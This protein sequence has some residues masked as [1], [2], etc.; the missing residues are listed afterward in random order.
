MVPITGRASSFLVFFVCML[1][2]GVFKNKIE[3][4]RRWRKRNNNRPIK[5][6]K[7]IKFSQTTSIPPNPNHYYTQISTLYLYTYMASFSS[8][9]LL[10]SPLSTANLRCLLV[11]TFS[12]LSFLSNSFSSPRLTLLRVA[13]HCFWWSSV[14]DDL[15]FSSRTFLVILLALSFSRLILSF[16]SSVL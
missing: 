9:A 6:P 2:A 4:R 1:E 13:R 14:S 16:L 11:T 8:L 7:V 10:S 15:F 3:R 12:G 5:L